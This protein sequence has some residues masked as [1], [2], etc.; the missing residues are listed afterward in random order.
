[1]FLIWGRSVRIPTEPE[2]FHERMGPRFRT[3]ISDYDTG[4]RL[5]IL[6]D[7]FL[8]AHVLRGRSVLEVGAGLGFFSARLKQCGAYVTASDIGETMLQKISDTIGCE[9]ELVDALS[10]V[11]HFGPNRFDLVLSSEC[12]EHTPDPMRAVEQMVGVLKPS[13]YIALSTPN[14]L[15]HPVVR[16]ATLLRLRQFQCLENFSTFTQLRQTLEQ[17]GVTVLEEYGLHL[18]PFQFPLH[19]LSRWCD[20]N[21]QF[22]RRLM[23]NICILGQKENR[24]HGG[25]DLRA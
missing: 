14:L 8:P 5:E 22:A 12:I 24:V 16:F 6:V 2:Y 9:C 4:R 3:A 13:G 1:M 19:G 7:R 23:I 17:A 11:D 25:K 10:L 20:R 15:W 18:F 21:L